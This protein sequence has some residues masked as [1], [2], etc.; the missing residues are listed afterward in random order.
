MPH[1]PLCLAV[2]NKSIFAFFFSSEIYLLSVDF[3][4]NFY[5]FQVI[6]KIS[7]STSQAFLSFIYKANK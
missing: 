6:W 3:D 5:W 7:S 4:A 2:E 1:F